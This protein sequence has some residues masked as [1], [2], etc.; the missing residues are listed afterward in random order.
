MK[1]L[2]IRS[3]FRPAQARLRPALVAVLTIFPLLL[4][5]G[6]SD[7]TEISAEQIEPVPEDTSSPENDVVDPDPSV[8]ELELPKYS[9][10]EEELI[11]YGEVLAY[12]YGID[13]PPDEW[14][15]LVEQECS[16]FTD[17]QSTYVYGPAAADVLE[18]DSRSG[19]LLETF[20]FLVV[21][22]DM[23]DSGYVDSKFE[24]F[25][26]E[27]ILISIAFLTTVIDTE[28]LDFSIADFAD[29]Y[30]NQLVIARYDTSTPPEP[31][32]SDPYDDYEED[33]IAPPE[34]P[35]SPPDYTEPDPPIE[36]EGNAGGPTLCD[37]GTVSNSS[38]SGTCSHHG[39]E[40]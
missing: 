25:G 3:F 10:D 1:H 16:T 2:L 13:V 26:S 9:I 18:D 27:A 40:R 21:G 11:Y 14:L 35:T 28:S 8:E 19:L 39:G 20:V 30:D 36:H 15:D 12:R 37:D 24:R 6:C 34:Y 33:E 7:L 17:D 32:Y 5:S 31:D 22:T 38:G 23:C 4:V 29:Y